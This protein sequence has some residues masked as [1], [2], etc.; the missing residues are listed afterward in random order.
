M[1]ILVSVIG[2]LFSKLKFVTIVV[3]ATLYQGTVTLCLVHRKLSD[4]FQENLNIYKNLMNLLDEII[5][6]QEVNHRNCKD[7]IQE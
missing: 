3:T 1:P 6:N 4:P 5:L 7:V 2:D